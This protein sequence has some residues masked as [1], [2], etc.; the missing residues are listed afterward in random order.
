MFFEYENES[1]HRT[2]TTK[3]KFTQLLFKYKCRINILSLR[4]RNT[5]NQEI[6]GL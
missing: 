6:V 3:M 2:A 1:F 4:L 5:A